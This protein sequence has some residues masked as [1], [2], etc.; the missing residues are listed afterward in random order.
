MIVEISMIAGTF[1]R[2]NFQKFLPAAFVFC[3]L[4]RTSRK[5]NLGSSR[6]YSR[7]AKL[8]CRCISETHQPHWRATRSLARGTRTQKNRAT[9]KVSRNSENACMSLAL[10]GIH[11][12]GERKR[13]LERGSR[14]RR[15]ARAGEWTRQRKSRS[16]RREL[17]SPLATIASSLT[18]FARRGMVFGT[19]RHP[20]LTHGNC[21][22]FRL[23][24]FLPF[25]SLPFL[26]LDSLDL[27]HSWLRRTQRISGIGSCDVAIARHPTM[28]FPI[29]LSLVLGKLQ[30]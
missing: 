11:E 6:E 27:R 24:Y 13:S 18:R 4:L 25:L 15:N 10:E 8:T 14:R 1:H 21:R 29:D 9:G 19:N 22:F 7:N 12:R 20:N 26:F 3:S 5:H 28:V 2:W 30:V 23:I 17:P 16:L